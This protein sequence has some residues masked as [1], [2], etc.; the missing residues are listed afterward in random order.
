MPKRTFRIRE[1]EPLFDIVSHGR[2]GPRETGGRLTPAQI[3]RIRRTVQRAPEA[4]VKVL[5][6]DSNDLKAVGKHLDYIG[7]YGKLELESDDGEHLAGRIGKALLEDWDL[8]IDDVRR[9]AT[10]AA[11]KGRK[12]PKLVHKLTFSMPPGTP[13]DKVRGAV[14]NFAQEEFWGQHRYAFALH[15][16][17]AHP[18]VHLV[19]KAVSEQGVRLNI[20]KAT[21]RH[22]RSEF[23][24]NLRLLGVEANATERAVRGETRNAKKD[25]IYRA[26]LRGDSTHTRART[27]L[28]ASELV[29]GKVQV[30]P[31]KSTLV[32]TRKEVER[33]WRATS[34]ILE[35]QGQT[36]LAAQVRRFAAQMP[37]VQTE[38]ERIRQAL[39]DRAREL[40]TKEK[41]VTR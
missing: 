6:R 29:N 35:H 21:L 7:R 26:S 9:Q 16:D 18:H 32:A 27:E 22:W 33:G 31:G 37:P 36:A 19:L 38:K 40:H 34:E 17:E 4:V 8:D 28:V 13:P 25:G 20:K 2:G 14:R 5:P 10:L 1:G 15:T 30:E 41:P 39:L 11:T 23:A 3:E 12:P 24:R